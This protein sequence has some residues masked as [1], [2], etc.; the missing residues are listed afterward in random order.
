[1][2]QP[3]EKVTIRL[4]ALIINCSDLTNTLYGKQG[5]LGESC[6]P[7]CVRTSHVELPQTVLINTNNALTPLGMCATES[8][9]A[10]VRNAGLLSVYT[11]TITESLPGG[12]I[13]CFWQL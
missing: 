10:T 11:A 2:V 9:T 8:I 4:W 7:P 13:L 1:M 5:C 12:A 6:H 3:K